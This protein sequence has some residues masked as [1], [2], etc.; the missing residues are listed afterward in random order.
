MAIKTQCPRCRQ[1]LSVPNKL[2]GSYASCPRCQGRFWVSKDAPVDGSASELIA[3]PPDVPPGWQSAIAAQSAT[4]ATPPVRPAG[5]SA[6]PIANAPAVP[7]RPQ[8]IPV[9]VP[10]V[11][12]SPG[13]PPPIPTA[14]V[15]AMPGVAPPVAPSQPRKVARLVTA[16]AAQSTLKLAA[17]GQLPHLQLQEI[18]KKDRVLGKSKSVSPL[19]LVAAWVFSVVMTVVIL[20]FNS[21]DTSDVTTNDKLDALAAIEKEY[22]AAPVGTELQPYQ[23][24]LRE[25]HQARCRGDHKAERQYYRKVLDLLRRESRSG[26]ARPGLEKLEKGI[27]G[28][29]DHDRKLEKLILTVQAE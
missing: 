2:A 7:F 26:T 22:F 3:A 11:A 12:S 21:G 16:E 19:L 24:Y 8:A 13:L 18:E 1:P 17:D 20:L 4:V 29:R 23:I 28:S 10:P 27:T 14:P 9:A 5:P 15:V 6:P 25:A